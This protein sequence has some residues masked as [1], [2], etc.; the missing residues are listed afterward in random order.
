MVVAVVAVVVMMIG[1]WTLPRS[2]FQES[3][4]PDS[5]QGG[6]QEEVSVV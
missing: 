3:L 2:K 1:V 6:V 5:D 4:A